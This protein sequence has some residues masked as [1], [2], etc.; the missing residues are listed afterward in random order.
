[1]LWKHKGGKEYMW[2]SICSLHFKHRLHSCDL[3][4]VGKW[5]E[6][7]AHIH[8]GILYK[9]NYKEWFRRNNTPEKKREL[10]EIFPGLR[11]G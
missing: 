8:G 3:C 11:S 2:F 5:V 6:K 4:A 1:M 10:A 7:N 9:N